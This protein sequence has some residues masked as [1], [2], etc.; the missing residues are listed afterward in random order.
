MTYIIS[1]GS[2]SSQCFS[3]YLIISR[4]E[5]ETLGQTGLSDTAEILDELVREGYLSPTDLDLSTSHIAHHNR[6]GTYQKQMAAKTTLCVS[7]S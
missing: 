5:D 4:W 2:L 6:Y 7:L 3:L 1:Y